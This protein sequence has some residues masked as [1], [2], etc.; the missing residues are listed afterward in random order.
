MYN[1]DAAD[2]PYGAGSFREVTLPAGMIVIEKIVY[3]D[4]PNCLIYSI[5]EF[6]AGMDRLIRNYHGKM[7]YRGIDAHNTHLKW[8][9]YFEAKGVRFLTAPIAA[10][11]LRSLLTIFAGRTKKYLALKS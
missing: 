5:P 11:A 4:N 1:H 10:F 9:G 7:E 6:G 8:Q 2:V 3:S